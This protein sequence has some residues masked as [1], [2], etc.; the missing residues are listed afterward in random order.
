LKLILFDFDKEIYGRYVEVRLNK[1]SG[2]NAL[3]ITGTTE[4]PDRKRCG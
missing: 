3:S 2:M 4:G 1:K